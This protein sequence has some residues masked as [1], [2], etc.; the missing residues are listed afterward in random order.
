[1]FSF[2]L[3]WQFYRELLTPLQA[4]M[5]AKGSHALWN[6]WIQLKVWDSLSYK[7]A[8]RFTPFFYQIYL[9][10]HHLW[11]LFT[12]SS[13]LTVWKARQTYHLFS[14]GHFWLWSAASWRDNFCQEWGQTKSFEHKFTLVWK[15]KL[16]KYAYEIFFYYVYVSKLKVQN[17]SQENKILVNKKPL[18]NSFGLIITQ[19]TSKIIKWTR[20]FICEK[21]VIW[22]WMVE[23]NWANFLL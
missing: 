11:L 2:V 23:W 16:P 18:F 5:L 3:N 8:H 20:I 17:V 6:G 10:G 22:H 12:K 19:N 14:V 7:K 13:M 9:A 21:Q 4:G 1:V 15:W